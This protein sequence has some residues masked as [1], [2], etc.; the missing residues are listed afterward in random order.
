MVYAVKTVLER[1][2]Q[3][4]YSNFQRKL[5]M[6]FLCAIVLI[7]YDA[8]IYTIFV[9]YKLIIYKYLHIY[10]QRNMKTYKKIIFHMLRYVF[11]GKYA[12]KSYYYMFLFCLSRTYFY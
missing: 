5:I 6:R 7:K 2:S 4:I 12:N 9:I 10:I 8:S 11:T 1:L 3:G